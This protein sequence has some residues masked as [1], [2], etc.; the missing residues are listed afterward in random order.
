MKKRLVFNTALLAGAS[1]LMR[2]IGMAF[3]AWL[4]GRIGAAGIGLYQLVMSVELLCITF[5]VSGIRFAVTRLVS[6]ELGMGRP[7]GVGGA[8][9]RCAVYSLLFGCAAMTLLFLSSEA[10]GFL[11]IGDA[12]T[13]LSLRILSLGLPFISMSSVLSGYF[14]ACGRV[15]KPALVHLVEQLVC[16]GLVAALLLR[17]PAGNI[18]KCCAAIT[19]GATVSDILSFAMML[20]AYVTDRRRHGGDVRRGP[21]LTSRMLNVALPLAMSSYARS[22]LST[23]EHLLVP[24]GLRKAGFSADSSLAGYGVINGMAMPIIGFPACLLLAV[25]ELIVPEL[26][27]AQMRGDDA[28]ISRVVSALLRNTLI[29]SAV[30]AVLL[31]IFADRLGNGIYRSAEAGRYIRLLAPLIP[32]MYT[33][34][35]TDGCLKGLGQHIWSMWINILDAL[36]GVVLVYT[37]LPSYALT[38]Y[39][40]II[41]WGELMNFALSLGRL[42]RVTKIRLFT[43]RRACE[44]AWK[45]SYK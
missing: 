9:S 7:G 23:L 32:A 38:A 19:T 13:V 6:E 33:D 29:F 10:I 11:W 22:A 26:T 35:V 36:C 31:F 44:S 3:Q 16:V 15:W 4:A 24:R 30:A 42:S 41:Y 39:I 43:W 2:C 27:E 1:I 12:R 20:A 14:T 34:M 8:I 17:A 5:A 45:C 37:L 18:E 25:A 40:C 21:R 28:K